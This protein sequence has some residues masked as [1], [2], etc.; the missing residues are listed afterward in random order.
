M[1]THVTEEAWAS[2]LK[3]R[4]GGR[5]RSGGRDNFLTG[6]HDEGD[7]AVCAWS[8]KYRLITKLIT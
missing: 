4:E 2:R 5:E 8:I 6:V 7:V 1:W 3:K